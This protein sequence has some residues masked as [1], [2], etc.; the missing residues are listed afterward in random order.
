M[1]KILFI[2]AILF[3]VSCK[4]QIKNPI[5]IETNQIILSDCDLKVDSL[6]KEND[7][8]KTTLIRANFFKIRVNYYRTI[9][10]KNPKKFNQFLRGW[11]NGLF[12]NQ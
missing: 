8:L 3:S 10:N 2:A 11:I 7:S 12:E 5:K 4:S 6:R 1:R 9:T